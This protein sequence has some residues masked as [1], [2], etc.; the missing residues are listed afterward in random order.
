MSWL[1]NDLSVYGP[2]PT[3]ALIVAV[4]GLEID[5]Q[6]CFGTMYVSPAIGTRFEYW[7][8][9]KFSTAVLG[10]GADT[11]VIGGT[12]PVLAAGILLIRLNVKA[13]SALVNGW[14]SLHLTPWRSV[15]VS[16]LPPLDQA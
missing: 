4:A 11:L 10:L 2:V 9:L 6:M 1:V 15:K 8:V 16:V 7:A 12:P 3:G 5:F 14:P 13:T